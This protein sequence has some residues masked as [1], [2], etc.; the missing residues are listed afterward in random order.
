MSRIVIGVLIYI[1]SSQTYSLKLFSTLRAKLYD[2]DMGK[3]SAR[4]SQ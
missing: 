2:L 4:N 1:P 3:R